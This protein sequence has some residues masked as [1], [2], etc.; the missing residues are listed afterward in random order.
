MSQPQPPQS[1]A[2][3]LTYYEVLNITPATLDTSSDQ[4]QILKKAY[5]RAL[6]LHH[7]DKKNKPTPSSSS[8]LTIDQI[9]TAYAILSSPSL[10]QDYDKAL[11][12]SN[13]S[14]LSTT[15][16]Q[17]GIHDID[18]DDLDFDDGSG[19]WYR[20]CR[21]GNPRGYVFG[22]G[23]LEEAA[24]FGEVMVGCLDCSLWLRVHFAVMEEDDG[25]GE[26]VM[27]AKTHD[28]EDGEKWVPL[29]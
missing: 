25:D 28:L 1:S 10:R 6:L 12:L 2:S 16:F 23:D 19:Q 21:C 13:Q 18:L 3:T 15:T 11:S 9:S 29:E 7:P 17:T 14:T 27:A 8:H 22:E 24:D 5:H 20:S 4:T 26:E